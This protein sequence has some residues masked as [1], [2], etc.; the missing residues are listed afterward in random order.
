MS[1]DKII[2]FP[3]PE[4]RIDPY[5]DLPRTEKSG[6]NAY[7][8]YNNDRLFPGIMGFD[9]E[10]VWFELYAFTSIPIEILKELGFEVKMVYIKEV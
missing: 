10:S 7:C 6:R 9:L 2:P 8:V 4:P 1:D 5:S 3:L